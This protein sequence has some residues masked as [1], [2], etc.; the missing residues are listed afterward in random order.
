MDKQA[1]NKIANGNGGEGEL[2]VVLN[3]MLTSGNKYQRLMA[4]GASV[5]LRRNQ[6]PNQI[7]SKLLSGEVKSP[8]LYNRKLSDF[9]NIWSGDTYKGWEDTEEGK[10]AEYIGIS[11]NRN[12]GRSG[13]Y[14]PDNIGPTNLPPW[15]KPGDITITRI[16]GRVTRY[17][18]EVNPPRNAI[19]IGLKPGEEDNFDVA[20]LRYEIINKIQN[21][22]IRLRGS[23]KKA[24]K[25]SQ[26]KDLDIKQP[27]LDK[28][29]SWAKALELNESLVEKQKMQVEI[30]REMGNSIMRDKRYRPDF[31][32]V[33]NLK[34]ESNMTVDEVNQ[35]QDTVNSIVN[36]YF[37]DKEIREF[38]RRG[39]HMKIAP[40]PEDIAGQNYGKEVIF[41]PST[42]KAA[43]GITEDVVVHELIHAQNRFRETD[44][45]KKYLRKESVVDTAKDIE[46][47]AEIEEAVTEAMTTARLHTYDKSSNTN[48]PNGPK[49]LSRKY[50]SIFK[51]MG[52]MRVEELPSGDQRKIKEALEEHYKM[53]VPDE[54]IFSDNGFNYRLDNDES[55]PSEGY[56]IFNLSDDSPGAPKNLDEMREFADTSLEVNLQMLMEGDGAGLEDYRYDAIDKSMKGTLESLLDEIDV[57]DVINADNLSEAREIGSRRYAFRVDRRENGNSG[58]TENELLTIMNPTFM[59]GEEREVALLGEDDTL[60]IDPMYEESGRF[61]VNPFDQYGDAYLEFLS[62]FPPRGV[63]LATEI[64]TT[65]GEM[66]NPPGDTFIA[67]GT[68][69]ELNGPIEQ[70]VL[71]HFDNDEEALRPELWENWQATLNLDAVRRGDPLN[72]TLTDA[73]VIKVAPKDF[74]SIWDIHPLYFEKDGYQYIKSHY[75]SESQKMIYR[76]R[77]R[78][79]SNVDNWID[80]EV[81]F[82]ALPNLNTDEMFDNLQEMDG[83][84]F[85]RIYSRYKDKRR[86]SSKSFDKINRGTMNKGAVGLVAKHVKRL[87]FNYRTVPVKGGK[88][89]LYIRKK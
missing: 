72:S 19:F 82:Y 31:K 39:V 61:V 28:Q 4:E 48:A 5:M 56:W 8:R 26:L 16:G 67:H 57:Q 17:D 80:E 64:D 37:T 71:G 55:R 12:R 74:K 69:Q 81:G 89:N 30:Q 87:G 63:D 79:A 83:S 54:L 34:N 1:L 47:D 15:L 45:P 25:A 36:N 65:L 40:L 32:R 7:A 20:A 86:F 73:E 21:D 62:T 52:N 66:E 88:Y 78:D 3:D 35:A 27:S 58:I 18:P 38:H 24:L 10:K 53:T 60:V 70:T 2:S 84:V 41:D 49:E 33:F 11:I 14:K 75:D 76:N 51:R 23:V 43:N 50:N 6:T 44:N 29:K 85:Q 77:T 22:E 59:T 68:F 9:A 46:N 13:R 42:V